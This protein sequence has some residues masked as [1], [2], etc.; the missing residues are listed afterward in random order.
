MQVLLLLLIPIPVGL[1]INIIKSEKLW[2]L[3]TIA[4]LSLLGITLY[5]LHDVVT[6]GEAIHFRFTDTGLLGIGLTLDLLTGTLSVVCAFLF[7]IYAIYNR[8][9]G[10]FN[11]TQEFY[12]LVLEP[13]IMLLFMTRDIFNLFVLLEV[14]TIICGTLIML[15]REKR[16]VYD[17]LVYI[18]INTIGI[19]FYLLG[20]GLLYR[21]FGNLDLNFLR[22]QMVT[23]DKGNLLLPY[24]FILTGLSVKS[25]LFPVFLWLPKAHGSPGAPAIVSALLSGIYIKAGVFSLIQMLL[26][27]NPVID[28]S[29]MVLVIGVISALWGIILAVL[30]KDI[31]L[32]LAYH[33]VSQIG[34]I[35][36]GI[37][38]FDDLS[39]YGGMMH[40]M[41]HGLFKS[42]L[43]LCV[44]NVFRLYGT[45]TITDIKGLFKRCPV[46][47][48]GLLFGILGITGA[49]LF[50][51]SISKYLI[52]S[53]FDDPVMAVF[54]HLINF[55]TTLSFVKLGSIL[56]GKSTRN[57]RTN[58]WIKT[59]III[60]SASVLL[61]GVFGFNIY[62]LLTGIDFGMSQA[63]FIEKAIHWFIYSAVAVLTFMKILPLFKVYRKGFNLD[64]EFNTTAFMTL[65]SFIL[66]Y[67]YAFVRVGL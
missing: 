37:S 50:N 66:Y 7:V 31:K 45:R 34:L 56:F 30:S 39:F 9:D 2:I 67:A 60:A 54:L 13:I 46:T 63:A 42:L 16:S 29:E 27:F 22:E 3:G 23:V 5:N 57:I 12:L 59:S 48:I 11:A 41:N 49:P 33:T 15:L 20:V 65:I 21:L 14:S 32:I 51:G 26:L 28:T 61:T 6:R 53:G 64:L 19:M 4:R 36:I 18:M 44:G 43:F 58:N 52:M 47:G 55:G 1:I 38:R 10:K 17:G 24:A 40:I 62:T 35:F 8:G 25:A